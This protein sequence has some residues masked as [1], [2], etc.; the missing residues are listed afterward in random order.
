MFGKLISRLSEKKSK[1]DHPLGSD[2]NVDALLADIPQ[3][4]PAR[5]LLD[6]DH[7]LAIIEAQVSEIGRLSATQALLRLDQFSWAATGVLLTRYLT[8]G[9]REYLVDSI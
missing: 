7:W 4:D 8:A 3:S 6:V 2:A 5:V 1:S 9:S